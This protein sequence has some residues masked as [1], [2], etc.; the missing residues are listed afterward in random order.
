M[1]QKRRQDTSDIDPAFPEDEHGGVDVQK[2]WRNIAN[3]FK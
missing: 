3:K 1:S 2:W